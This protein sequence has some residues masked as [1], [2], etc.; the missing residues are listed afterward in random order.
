[1]PTIIQRTISFGERM[2]TRRLI[3]LQKIKNKR[4]TIRARKLAK[5]STQ[6]A[7]DNEI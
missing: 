7:D 3:K 1:M 2:N 6:V 4:S 5:V